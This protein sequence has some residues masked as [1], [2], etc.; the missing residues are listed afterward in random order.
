MEY[1]CPGLDRVPHCPGLVGTQHPHPIRRQIS[2]ASTCYAAGV[3]YPTDGGGGVPPLL[4][5]R[6]R[7]FLSKRRLLF[8]SKSSKNIKT[9]LV[10]KI[11]VK[12]AIKY[13]TFLIPNPVTINHLNRS[14]N[15][16]S[17]IAESIATGLCEK[18]IRF[19]SYQ[20]LT[21]FI[22]SQQPNVF[23]SIMHLVSENFVAGHIWALMFLYTLP[24]QCCKK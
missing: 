6:R 14:C 18:Y 19:L 13:Y 15:W 11:L 20:L 3:P 22:P 2:I 24:V 21:Y 4:R 17:C 8:S 9:T 5:S 12:S 10:K 23:S 1:P 7:T 16:I